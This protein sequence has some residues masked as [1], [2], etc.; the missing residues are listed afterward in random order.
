MNREFTI[1]L[2]PNAKASTHKALNRFIVVLAEENKV[3]VGCHPC[4]VPCTVTERIV[5]DPKQR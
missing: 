5:L 3:T 2:E 4:Q 1:Q